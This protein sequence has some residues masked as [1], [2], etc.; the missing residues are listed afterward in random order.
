MTPELRV[1]ITTALAPLHGWTTPEKGQTLARLILETGADRSVEI[2]VF[3]GRGT[4]AMA[5]AHQELGKGYVSGIDPWD[6]QASLEGVNDSANDEWWGKLDHE[7][8]YEHFLAALVQH[9]IGRYCR[10]MRERS[11]TA[12]RLFAD[13]T[14]AVLHQD[15]NHS[16]QVSL[17]EVN[18]W[19]P[20]LASGGYWVADD[21]EWAT[22]QRALARLAELG[23]EPIEDHGSWRVYRKP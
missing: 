22:T 19:S 1:R 18:L 4:I 20:K 8:I 5:M 23:F 12:V 14:V 7:A 17:T 16:E 11:D 6:V 10:I 9:G 15:G 21:V 13:A 2:G 3:G